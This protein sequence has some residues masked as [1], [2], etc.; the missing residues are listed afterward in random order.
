MNKLSI[1]TESHLRLLSLKTLVIFSSIFI[2]PELF[3]FST[4]FAEYIPLEIGSYWTYTVDNRVGTFETKD[5]ATLII[6]G[7][8]DVDGKKCSVMEAR[9]GDIVLTRKNIL[10][11]YLYDNRN[12]L[13]TVN[14]FES[15]GGGVI[16]D[17]EEY[18]N[19]YMQYKYPFNIGM[20]WTISSAKGIEPKLVLLLNTKM[21]DVDDDDIDD[22]VDMT[23]KVKVVSIEDINVPA[24]FFKD[25]YK[26]VYTYSM[27]VHCSLRGDLDLVVSDTIWFKPYTGVIMEEKV[28]GWPSLFDSMEQRTVYKLSEYSISR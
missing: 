18:K 17:R 2:L 21:N 16:I 26:I 7:E 10:R 9:V 22:I 12:G 27:K 13:I 8:R 20:S 19:G 14:G 6:V 11:T 4:I 3:N 5:S 24:G 28:S 23:A 25:C 1:I 15:E